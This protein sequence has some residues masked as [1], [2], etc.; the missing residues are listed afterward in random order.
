MFWSIWIIFGVQTFLGIVGSIYQTIWQHRNEQ[1]TKWY[2][3]SPVDEGST[4]DAG[5][6]ATTFLTSMGT[7]FLLVTSLIPITLMVTIEI[8]KFGQAQFIAWDATIWDNT[9]DLPALA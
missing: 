4:W 5:T 8:V 7:W 9:R 2:L 1:G 6:A 3:G